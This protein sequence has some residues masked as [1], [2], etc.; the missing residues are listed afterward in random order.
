MNISGS[1]NGFEELIM[2]FYDESGFSCKSKAF[3][4]L[5]EKIGEA[6][7]LDAVQKNTVPVHNGKRYPFNKVKNEDH[8][9]IIFI[10]EDIAAWYNT[11]IFMELIGNIRNGVTNISMLLD[12]IDGYI[13]EKGVGSSESS[14]YLNGIN[15]IIMVI[16]LQFMFVALE[17]EYSMGKDKD[18]Y[19]DDF[20]D[21]VF[22]AEI[23]A[24]QLTD[25]LR[26]S[27]ITVSVDRNEE[28]ICG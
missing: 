13:S 6:A 8:D 4:E 19:A 16:W 7:I 15:K 14:A 1:A 23:F 12:E 21:V 10:E 3:L 5:E 20:F 11:D 17:Q 24:G 9:L 25:V 27:G 22:I 18:L 26:N 2:A 28:D